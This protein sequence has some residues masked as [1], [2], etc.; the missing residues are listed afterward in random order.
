MTK[1]TLRSEL[2]LLMAAII[3]GFAFVSQRLGLDHI[4]PFF[5]NAVRFALGGLILIP[6]AWCLNSKFTPAGGDPN[7]TPNTQ[8]SNGPSLWISGLLLGGFLF[9]GASFQQVGLLYTTAGN[10]GF[11]TGLYIVIVPFIGMF[12]GQ[13][14]KANTWVGAVF[15]VLG[16]YLLSVK[17]GFSLAYGDLLQL[18]GACF[19]AGHVLLIGWLS[20]KHNPIVLSVMQFFVCAAFSLIV[21]LSIETISLAGL[22]AGWAS[23][24]YTGLISVGI[25]YTC[26]VI[27]QRNV[28]PSHSAIIL[29]LEA[30]F[31]VIGG[32]FF[33]SETHSVKSLLGCGLMLTGM[34]ISQFKF[35][36]LKPRSKATAS[37]GGATQ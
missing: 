28:P 1:T 22:K 8:K 5:F 16:L 3:W 33:L 36:Q 18:A 24:A 37:Y 4:E 17:E 29:S 27:G 32:Y 15:A 25:G 23:V 9:L 6:I 7:R 34:L 10:A 12:F 21:A 26:Q 2:T 19:W 14:T 13:S 31:A 35:P 11:I 30:V 20:P